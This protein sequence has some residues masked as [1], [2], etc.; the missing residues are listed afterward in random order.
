VSENVELVRASVEAFNRGDY[1][2]WL[3]TIDPEIVFEPLRAP[4]EGAYRG[5][6]GIRA[7]L[8]D[9]TESFEVF[10][11]EHSDVRDLGNERVLAIGTVHL[12]TKESG[13]ETDVPT[14]A[15]ASTRDGLMTHWKDYGDR[16]AALK[17][18]GLSD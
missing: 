6:A 15:I 3:A 11:I 14:A 18:A 5:Q 10:R 1:E 16:D 13:I 12:K 4:I 17:A 2:A 7:Y 8:A 9:T